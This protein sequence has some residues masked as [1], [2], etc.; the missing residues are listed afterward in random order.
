M[1]L[2]PEQ[3]IE[4]LDADYSLIENSDIVSVSGNSVNGDDLHEF[5]YT[6]IDNGEKIVAE[7][8]TVENVSGY[9]DQLAGAA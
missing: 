4:N 8:F 2:T 7:V 9:I 5:M 1:N 6:E 3:F